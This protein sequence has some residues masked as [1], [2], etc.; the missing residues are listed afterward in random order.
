MFLPLG[1]ANAA[2]VEI[3]NRSKE[4]RLPLRD[5]RSQEKLKQA[6]EVGSERCGGRPGGARALSRERGERKKALSIRVLPY[7]SADALKQIGMFRGDVSANLSIYVV[8]PIELVLLVCRSNR[9]A[10]ALSVRL[11]SGFHDLY[12]RYLAVAD[13]RVHAFS[14]PASSE[15][16]R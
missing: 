5:V 8:S 16:K 6:T 2:L 11:T 14:S 4:R 3:R 7:R 9:T 10:E 13:I 1:R 15:L 12:H